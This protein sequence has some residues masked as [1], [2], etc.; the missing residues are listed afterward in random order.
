M[1]IIKITEERM[2]QILPQTV[3]DSDLSTSAKKVLATII[4]YHLVNDKVRTTGFLAIGNEAL[5]ESSEIGKDNLRAAIQELIECK[6]IER[7]VGQKWKAG[8]T[9]KASEYRLN[10][11]NI[12][13]PIQKPTSED[14]LEMLFQTP[15]KPLCTKESPTNTYT[16]TDTYTNSNTNSDTNTDTNSNIIYNINKNN[17][18]LGEI[19][20]D[21]FKLL[22]EFIEDTFRDKKT[23]QESVSQIGVIFKWIKDRYSEKHN[24]EMLTRYANNLISNKLEVF[25]TV[26]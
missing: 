8:E 9:K 2:Q 5:R 6:L 24:V 11:E 19:G 23:Y 18:I 20:K 10:I 14:L 13:K 26:S 16:N 4:N 7:K 12:R 3:K 15:L 17:N 21:K 22:E 1:E 25:K